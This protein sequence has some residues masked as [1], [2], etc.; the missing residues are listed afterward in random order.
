MADVKNEQIPDVG[1]RS[2]LLTTDGSGTGTL[3]N[4][5]EAAIGV[6]LRDPDSKIIA[7][8]SEPIGR[9]T[10]TIAEYKAFIA[11]MKLAHAREIKLH[12]HLRRFRT[13]RRPDQCGISGN[14]GL[15]PSAACGGARAIRQI[16][17]QKNRLDPAEVEPG[18]GQARLGRATA[19]TRT[20]EDLTTVY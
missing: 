18:G 20:D 16:Q 1:E 6:V 7:T 9:A 19:A 3:E 17:E 11:G 8:I 14:Q 4:P 15:P 5:S 12:T 2:Y 13:T 10:N